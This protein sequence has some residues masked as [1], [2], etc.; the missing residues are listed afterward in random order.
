MALNLAEALLCIDCEEIYKMDNT[1]SDSF[2]PKCTSIYFIRL[3][4]ILN[5]IGDKR[6]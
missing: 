5:N 1:I 6:E 4:P 3:Y 2:C